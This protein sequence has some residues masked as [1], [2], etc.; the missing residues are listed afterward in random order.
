MSYHIATGNTEPSESRSEPDASL[1]GLSPGI[2]DITVDD[3]DTVSV[4]NR[5]ALQEADWSKRDVIGGA[6]EHALH[7]LQLCPLL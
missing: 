1:V 4:N 3:G 5:R 2:L 6:L 7:L